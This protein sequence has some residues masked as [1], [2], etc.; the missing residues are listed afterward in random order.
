MKEINGYD[1]SIKA[2]RVLIRVYN[3]RSGVTLLSK[4]MEDLNI[5]VCHI[6]K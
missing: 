5:G 2:I 1:I 6:N 3:C 4:T